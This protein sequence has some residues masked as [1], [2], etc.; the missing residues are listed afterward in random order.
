MRVLIRK[1]FGLVAI[2]LISLCSLLL[3]Y[4]SYRMVGP[5]WA[6]LFANEHLVYN[7]RPIEIWPYTI[8]QL[9]ISYGVLLLI[10][11][12]AVIFIICKTRIFNRHIVFLVI[13][14]VVPFILYYLSAHYV[15]VLM[16]IRFAHVAGYAI[17]GILLTDFVRELIDNISSKVLR[18]LLFL[19]VAPFCTIII[20]LGW[21]DYW[22][23]QFKNPSKFASQLS[24]SRLQAI[25]WIKNN[26]PL[27]SRIFTHYYTGSYLP[28]YSSHHV[29][30]GHEL[31]TLEFWRKWE[32]ASNF[33]DGRMTSIDARNFFVREGLQYLFWDSGI[34]PVRY[35][36]LFHQLYQNRDVQIYQFQP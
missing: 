3:Y 18:P 29:Y 2:L 30:L 24:V 19:L 34:L 33:I 32:E 8:W 15:I 28:A 16:K 17:G 13:I 25:S 36:S 1:H 26:L 21:N 7:H 11:P 22:F 23:D 31:M 20:L 6:K 10:I 35:T 27:R 4:F 14:F 9:L 5:I 12:S